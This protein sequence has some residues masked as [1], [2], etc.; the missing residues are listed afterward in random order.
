M[1]LEDFP[2]P[3]DD[4]GFGI[5]FGLDLR[6]QSLETFTARMT[7][8]RLKWCLVPHEDEVQLARA[9][10]V[11]S[12]AGIFPISRWMCQI[13]QNI[14][15]FVRFVKVLTDLQLPAYVQIFNEPSDL[16]EWRDG[17]PKPR[18][19]TARWCD[20]AAR[21]ADAGGLPGL[22]VL[23][24]SELR[25]VL[26][27]LKAR[28]ATNVLERMWFCP[29]PYGAN[30]PPDYPYDKR[31]QYDHPGATVTSDDAT[32]LS[33]LEFAPVFEAELGFVPPFIA[34]EGGWQYGNAEDGRYPK[35]GE[36]NHAEYHAA[37]FNWF[38]SGQLSNGEPLPDYVF[39][40]CPWILFGHEADAWYSWTTGTREATINAI[41]AIPPFVRKLRASRPPPAPVLAHYVLFG[42][43]APEQ[44]ARLLLARDYLTRF[45]VAFGFSL[46]EARC[47]RRVTI[48]GDH[49]VVS[50]EEEA[51]L[52]RAGRRIERLLG[53][54]YALQIILSDRLTR[55]AEFG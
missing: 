43:A 42:H 8:L 38:R 29:H 34:G 5:H 37:L 13:D 12:R 11:M 10:Q 53:D 35:V 39:A 21:V 6:P 46:D 52:K 14:L 48:V 44:H 2:R 3:A 4:N 50:L 17:V 26:A 7:A 22:Q 28:G 40:F 45:N 36:T 19:F 27:E 30:H 41:K 16:R 47:A 23:D 51:E 24:V 54:D 1:H 33:F 31:N 15:D 55:E 25:A 18:A 32:V 9:A 20:H 49:T